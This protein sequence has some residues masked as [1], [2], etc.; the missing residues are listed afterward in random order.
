MPTLPRSQALGMEISR[1]WSAGAPCLHVSTIFT[2][3]Q[4]QQWYLSLAW[5]GQSI[6]LYLCLSY[7]GSESCVTLDAEEDG[8]CCPICVPRLWFFARRVAQT[9]WSPAQKSL[10]QSN[11]VDLLFWRYQTP[12]NHHLWYKRRI[13]LQF[14]VIGL[15][16]SINSS[17]SNS[18]HPIR[19]Y[20]VTD[21]LLWK[22]LSCT[23]IQPSLI[24]RDSICTAQSSG[25]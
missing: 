17:S 19:E 14:W 16:N 10:L 2:R 11:I 6:R 20:G 12:Y 13:Y 18:K 5:K 25:L 3:R 24:D 7:W 9:S 21:L 22:D 8:D 15:K 4:R 23:C 1:T